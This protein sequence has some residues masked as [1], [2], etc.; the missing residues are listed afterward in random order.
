MI[1]LELNGESR[2]YPLQILTWHEIAN[3]SLAG[4]P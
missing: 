1:A 2:A 3:D 4:V